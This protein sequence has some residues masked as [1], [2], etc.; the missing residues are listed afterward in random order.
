MLVP[1]YQ[2]LQNSFSSF[3]F[4]SLF[5]LLS[6][7]IWCLL[8]SIQ[9]YCLDYVILI[10]FNTSILRWIDFL[11]NLKKRKREIETC[12][13]SVIFTSFH[14]IFCQFL[15]MFTLIVI[16]NQDAIAWDLAAIPVNQ[17]SHFIK[18]FLVNQELILLTEIL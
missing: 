13:S 1:K 4:V 17:I 3:P 6:F 5:P 12:I 14:D 18:I 8:H 10:Q 2:K 16:N 11:I 15:N 9:L 7:L